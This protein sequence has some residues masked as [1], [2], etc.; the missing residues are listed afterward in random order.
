MKRFFLAFGRLV[1]IAGIFGIMYVASMAQHFSS[2]AY[3]VAI[4]LWLMVFGGLFR[5]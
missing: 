5:A 4:F 1:A 3:L 2:T